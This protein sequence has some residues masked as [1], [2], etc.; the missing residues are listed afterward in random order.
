MVTAATKLKLLAPRK[1]SYEKPR[2]YMKKQRHYLADKGPSGQSYGFSSSH[3][4][5]WELDHK[6]A[7]SW[8]INAFKLWCWRILIRVPWAA[9]RS[10]QLILKE[11]NPEYSLEGLMLKLKLQYFFFFWSSNILATWCKELT[12][13]KRT[14][15]WERLRA[16]GEG[17]DRG[18]NDWMAYW[19]NGHEFEQTLGDSEGQGSLVCCSPWGTRVRHDWVTKQQQQKKKN[20][21][22]I[23]LQIEQISTGLH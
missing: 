15:R 8:R 6:E 23:K 16:G 13:W 9:R 17:G 14:Q 22:T 11:I 20:S 18:W 4:R 1:K 19:I 3:V 12:H 7:E 2:Q 5:M 21:K 10:N